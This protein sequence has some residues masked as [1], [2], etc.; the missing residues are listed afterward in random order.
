MPA[1]CSRLAA[2]LLA[3]VLA[4]GVVAGPAHAE[5][6]SSPP[7]SVNIR[8][9][10][11]ESVPACV[12][13]ARLMAHVRE[14]NGRLD[15]RFARIATYYKQHGEALR[16][17][18]DY[19]F[20]QMLIET[21]YLSYKTGSGRWGDVDPKQN[22]FA[23]IGTTGGGVPGDSFKDVS[24]GVL[25]QMQH[26]VAYS[27][28]RIANPV[29]ARTMEKQDEIIELSRKLKRP[30]RFSDLARRWAVDWRY[31][32]SIEYV[33]QRYRKA[34]CRDDG[35]PLAAS[36][37]PAE[38]APAKSVV[39][40]AAGPRASRPPRG[41]AGA[42]ET[43]TQLAASPA[44]CGIWTASYGGS[45]A[46]LIRSVTGATTNYTVLQVEAED[47]AAQVDAFVRTHAQ[48]GEMVGRYGSAEQAFARAFELCP[49]PS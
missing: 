6:G 25:G 8:L 38:D 34:Y 42:A 46:F 21:N 12:T 37:D 19:A 35:Q 16:V 41:G 1:Q 9:A 48:G 3:P 49:R 32:R 27:G 26:L 14:R 44:G 10:P 2:A 7:A 47:E 15:P 29:A 18:W 40:A 5:R 20:F 31:G 45:V 4:A 36:P 23:G 13:P 24:T 28:E 33:A 43:S 39:E 11:G 17:R 30:V 22:N